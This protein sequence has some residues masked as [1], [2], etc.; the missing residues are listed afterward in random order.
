MTALPYPPF[1]R[2]GYSLG[3][4]DV[5]VNG[6]AQPHGK[7]CDQEAMILVHNATDRAGLS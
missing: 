3:D 4:E 6:A 7:R 2:M 1:P 5:L